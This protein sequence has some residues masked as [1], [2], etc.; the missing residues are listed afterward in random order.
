MKVDYELTHK[1]AVK[2]E[3]HQISVL[4]PFIYAVVVDFVTE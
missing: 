2:V 1:F 4:T 3:K